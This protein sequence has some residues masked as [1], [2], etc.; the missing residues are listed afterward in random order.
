MINRYKGY[1]KC[2]DE[3]VPAGQG[4]YEYGYSWCG[5]FTLEKFPHMGLYWREEVIASAHHKEPK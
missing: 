5:T 3:F 2:C 4:I 1:C